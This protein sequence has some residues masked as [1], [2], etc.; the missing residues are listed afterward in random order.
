MTYRSPQSIHT[1]CFP[2]HTHLPAVSLES[3]CIF[4]NWTVTFVNATIHSLPSMAHFMAL[5]IAYLPA[6][7]KSDNRFFCK[8]EQL[9]FDFFKIAVRKRLDSHTFVEKS[10]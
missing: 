1:A 7:L 2:R 10:T 6:R 4:D 3:A 5:T 8:Y 9:L